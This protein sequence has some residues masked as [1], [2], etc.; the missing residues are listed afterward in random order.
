MSI[1]WATSSKMQRSWCFVSSW[2][3]SDVRSHDPVQLVRPGDRRPPGQARATG[4]LGGLPRLPRDHPALAPGA[5][6]PALD[7]PTPTAGTTSPIGGDGRADRPAGR[8][9]SRWGCRR[10]HGE[11]ATM[12]TSIAPSSVWAIHKRHVSRHRTLAAV[13]AILGRVPRRSGKGPDR[14]RLLQRRTVVLR[15]LCVLF[16]IHHDTRLVRIAGVTANPAADWVT[17]GW[18]LGTHKFTRLLTGFARL[19]SSLP[20]IESLALDS[21]AP[22]N[23]DSSRGERGVPQRD[24]PG[25]VIR[26]ADGDL[27]PGQE[28]VAARGSTGRG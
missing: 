11:L 1:G 20:G 13:G 19:P 14:L 12:G 15:W 16:F 2:P 22:Q 5:R 18:V 26:R 28:L 4:A 8:E 21:V 10:I 6:P 24:E 23:M 3:Y 7:L 27:I 9:N 25:D 17:G